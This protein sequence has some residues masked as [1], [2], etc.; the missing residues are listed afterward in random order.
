MLKYKHKTTLVVNEVLE[1][2]RL[3]KC[4]CHVLKRLFRVNLFSNFLFSL[5]NGGDDN[6]GDEEEDDDN[7]DDVNQLVLAVIGSGD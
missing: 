3:L 5:L 2:A 7:D 1:S 6:D 4:A